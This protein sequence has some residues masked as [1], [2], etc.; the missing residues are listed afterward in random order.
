MSFLDVCA[1]TKAQ[2]EHLGTSEAW[3]E[4]APPDHDGDGPVDDA[5]DLLVVLA[6]QVQK[7]LV[8]S[9]ALKAE[10]S[11]SHCYISHKSTLWQAIYL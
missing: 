10:T 9:E 1:Q 11:H 6:A 2:P 3:V 8:A 4:L 5:D 7:H